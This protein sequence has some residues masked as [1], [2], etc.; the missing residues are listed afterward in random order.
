MSSDQE[1]AS[2]A[3]GQTS[4]RR[5]R[6]AAAMKRALIL[7]GVPIF[8]M[9]VFH[10]L[11]S[12][13]STHQTWSE[14]RSNAGR[15]SVLMPVPPR[16]SQETRPIFALE[17]TLHTFT[18]EAAG[19]SAACNVSYADY[20]ES[21]M[22]FMDSSADEMLDAACLASTAGGKGKLL[23]VHAITMS[24]YPGRELLFEHNVKDSPKFVRGRLY[25]VDRRFYL[26]SFLSRRRSL[27]ASTDGETFLNS[28]KLIGESAKKSP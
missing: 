28:F 2:A 18:A 13:P 24:G 15:F 22:K 10:Y 16:E 21:L 7:L 12:L 20:E 3:L 9:V 6:A 1:P 25:F 19:G 5:S 11:S 23:E 8:G 17:M 4:A 27:V 26:L 14:F